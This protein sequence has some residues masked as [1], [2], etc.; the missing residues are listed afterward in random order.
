MD[1]DRA[2]NKK[3][4]FLCANCNKGLGML[5]DDPEIL[6]KAIE[7]L[8]CDPLVS[9]KMFDRLSKL[10]QYAQTGAQVYSTARTFYHIGQGA[11]Q[12]ARVAAPIF[13][14]LL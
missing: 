11:V 9:G 13:G 2:T 14:A 1:H 6:A 4:G 3:R 8:R 12:I 10:Q 7:Y 5:K